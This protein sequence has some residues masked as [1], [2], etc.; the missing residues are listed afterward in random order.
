M[1]WYRSLWVKGLAVLCAAILLFF[2]GLCYAFANDKAGMNEIFTYNDF[3]NAETY[4][5]RLS[6]A[7][8]EIVS[9]VRQAYSGL[10]VSPVDLQ[11]GVVEG[12]FHY[13]FYVDGTVLTDIP[14]LEEVDFSHAK[15]LAVYGGS[16]CYIL[17]TIHT[18]AEHFS[19][20]DG[21]SW[22][23]Y[24]LTKT[25]SLQVFS[26]DAGAILV[27][28]TEWISE[29]YAVWSTAKTRALMF[30]LL[31]A[32]SFVP[33]VYLILCTV[34]EKLPKT[35]RR[36]RIF[37][38]ILLFIASGAVV[39]LFQVARLDYLLWLRQFLALFGRGDDSYVYAAFSLLASFLILLA[40]FC[41]VALIRSGRQ[42]RL[43]KDS[44]IYWFCRKPYETLRQWAD[45][46]YFRRY[47]YSV[48]F[49]IRTV[50]LVLF[51]AVFVTFFIVSVVQEYWVVVR[52]LF[53]FAAL[54][55]MAVYVFGSVRDFR[56]LNGILEHITALQEGN[57]SFRAPIGEESVFSEYEA[58][59]RSVGDGF[60]HT[61]RSQIAA[62]RS[63]VNLITNVSHDLR[64]PLT[65]II[66]YIDLLSKTDLNDE[67]RDY[68]SILMQ[69]SNRLNHLVSD[70]FA[71]SKANSG[72]EEISVESL[73]LF[74]LVRQLVA[75]LSDAADAAGK[76]VRLSGEGTAI[77]SSNGNKIYRILQN[78][79]D[80]ALKYSLAGT[81]IFV[82]M[83]R[84]ETHAS[85]TVKNTSSYEMNFSAEEIS[86][87]FVRGDPARTGEG[88]GLGLAIAKTFAEQLNAEFVISIDGDQFSSTV[89]FPLQENDQKTESNREDL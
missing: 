51:E 19:L 31:F 42:G 80:N 60:D 26:C 23:P 16:N 22:N 88:S 79:L 73:D 67:A 9:L 59:L 36:S 35:V 39:F 58:Q 10:R 83:K 24:D 85:V 14:E 66:G 65:S 64:T 71:L 84:T 74:L 4:G 20:V 43:W 21:Y 86:E 78:M 52:I 49:L 53:L 2:S 44:F 7:T 75:D 6:S 11:G 13:Y 17:D 61:L 12:A 70:V 29:Q 46:N 32:A 28:D 5:D 8:E 76:T 63:R 57:L 18:Q 33:M 38:E 15:V 69:K 40:L 41:I 48:I 82:T 72:A 34:W 45:R 3:R 62:E 89:S 77:I 56:A 1:T 27:P 30:M 87:Q 54:L 81:R 55:A 25:V 47:R 50:L 68:V 37:P